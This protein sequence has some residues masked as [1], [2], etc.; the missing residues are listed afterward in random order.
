MSDYYSKAPPYG[1]VEIECPHC[2]VTIKMPVL[3]AITDTLINVTSA[4]QDILRRKGDVLETARPAKC[5]RC[6]KPIIIYSYWRAT[7]MIRNSH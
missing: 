7:W 5:P 3:D 4:R 6:K 1:A 2:A